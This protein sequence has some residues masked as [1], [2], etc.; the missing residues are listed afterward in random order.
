ML[1]RPHGSTQ[2]NLESTFTNIAQA[3]PVDPNAF[4]ELVST[5]TAPPARAPPTVLMPPPPAP[6]NRTEPTIPS[7]EAPQVQPL[8][9]PQTLAANALVDQHLARTA[10]TTPAPTEPTPPPE[11]EWGYFRISNR[12]NKANF[13]LDAVNLSIKSALTT[14]NISADQ[15]KYFVLPGNP[16]GPFT[17]KASA[18]VVQFFVE[19]QEVTLFC[20]DAAEDFE[21]QLCDSIGK[22]APTAEGSE[23]HLKNKENRG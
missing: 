15:N 8:S 4:P 22:L 20:D 12:D 11:A 7:G 13:L 19:L 1:L 3:V 2:L 6:I 5:W 9:A 21:V 14:T 23:R 10:E 17:V 16:K 18:Q